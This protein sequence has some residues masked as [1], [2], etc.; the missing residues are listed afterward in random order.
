MKSNS[1]ESHGPMESACKELLIRRA[2]QFV[3]LLAAFVIATRFF[4]PGFFAPL[5]PSH[6]D[7]WRYF[8]SGHQP[9]EWTLLKYPRPVMFF[10]FKLFAVTPNFS[11]F[12][13]FVL[14]TSVI[15]PYCALVVYERLAGIKASLFGAFLY[16]LVCFS[17]VTFYQVQTLD[18]GGCVSIILISI[19]ILMVERSTHDAQL[20]I[21][22]LLAAALLCWVAMEAKLTYAA[23]LPAIPFLFSRRL[24]WKSVFVMVVC[25]G[26]ISF[27]VL[28]KDKLFHS[29]FVDTTG[30]T[31][32]AYYMA[33]SVGELLSGVGFYM[34]HLAPVWLYPILLLAAVAFGK[35]YGWLALG[36]LV[37]MALL[38]LLPVTV[39]PNNRVPMY[40]WF[41]SVIL[42]LPLVELGAVTRVTT[43]HVGQKLLIAASAFLFLAGL[44]GVSRW[45][46]DD[47]DWL[48]SN[49]VANGNALAAMDVLRTKIRPG[50]RVLLSGPLNAYSPLKDDEFMASQFPFQF[51]WSVAIRTADEP[52]IAMSNATR[53]MVLA[54]DVEPD[55]FDTV[56]YFDRQGRLVKLGPASELRDLNKADRIGALLCGGV[57]STDS[58]V[59]QACLS[60][61]GEAQAAQ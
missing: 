61:L 52:F 29:P 40:S 2:V 26:G 25:A 31:S 17:L 57:S 27:I 59:V 12:I 58:H 49:Q 35:R 28:L 41:G 30:N 21:R 18:F 4:V 46:P 32:S 14:A 55:K 11:T 50:E 54:R 13:F 20:D 22:G 8:S 39:L 1:N 37:V 48:I 33:H 56:A 19:A 45:M 15:G 36:W 3:V 7:P 60:S 6:S 43:R 53:R 9:F 5:V 47:R 34:A 51:E 23:L 44:V 42:F 16:F 38:S 24:S 10:L